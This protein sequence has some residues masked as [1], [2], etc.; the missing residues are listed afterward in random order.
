MN[1]IK[2]AFGFQGISMNL[3]NE[4]EKNYHLLNCIYIHIYI[5]Q[6][7]LAVSDKYFFKYCNLINENKNFFVKYVKRS[8]ENTY[9]F[10]SYLTIKVFFL[11]FT[12]IFLHFICNISKI[13]YPKL[14]Q[15]WN[16]DV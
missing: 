9:D 3:Y 2:S 14:S 4:N 7:M 1:T 13:I 10:S 11:Y 5:A 6:E 8:L 15:K 16:H 12:K